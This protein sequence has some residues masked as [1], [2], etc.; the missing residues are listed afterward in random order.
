MS[1]SVVICFLFLPP[2]SEKARKHLTDWGLRLCD[3]T[4]D[5][6]SRVFPE[7]KINFGRRE[8]VAR[9]ADWGRDASNNVLD[10]VS[11]LC[12][13]RQ[14]VGDRAVARRKSYRPLCQSIALHKD[15]NFEK[16]GAKS[17]LLYFPRTF[18]KLSAGSC[19]ND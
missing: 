4:I 16:F 18:C 19:S 8:V 7:E 9:N 12:G 11:W 14:P 1:Q 13:C 10:A 5:L 15:V 3:D 6:D 2:E 17:F